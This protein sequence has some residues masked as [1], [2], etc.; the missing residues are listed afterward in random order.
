[1]AL[2]DP[3]GQEKTGRIKEADPS[4][5]KTAI[6]VIWGFTTNPR[7]LFAKLPTKGQEGVRNKESNLNPTNEENL[8]P[9][10]S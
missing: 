6:K 4:Q 10:S 8:R 3:N 5:N 2:R 1:M 9:L 7:L